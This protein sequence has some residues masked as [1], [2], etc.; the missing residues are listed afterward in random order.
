MCENLHPIFPAVSLHTSCSTLLSGAQSGSGLHILVSLDADG[1]ATFHASRFG[2][3]RWPR[4]RCWVLTQGE[5]P[6]FGLTGRSA[7]IKDVS[8]QVMGMVIIFPF[9]SILSGS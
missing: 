5:L 4:V 8:Q 1:P 3:L 7:E 6:L 2:S 9:L